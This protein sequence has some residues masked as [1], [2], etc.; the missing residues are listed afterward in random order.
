MR[1]LLGGV[2]AVC[3]A[4][5]VTLVILLGT[6]VVLR[7]GFNSPFVWAEEA[8]QLLFLW[9]SFLGAAMAGAERRHMRMELLDKYGGSRTEKF[10]EV[11]A[12]VLILICLSVVVFYGVE[13]VLDNLAR[14]SESLGVSY[15]LFYGAIPV[16]CLLYLVFE[17]KH[18]LHMIKGKPQQEESETTKINNERSS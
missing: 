3:L 15:A 11:A 4:L 1:R 6:N 16:G 9:L 17:A 12:S 14:R 13:A 2:K 5:I 10:R 8:G 18:L 7:Y